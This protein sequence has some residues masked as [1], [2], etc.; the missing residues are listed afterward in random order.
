MRFCK[1]FLYADINKFVTIRD[2]EDDLR[3]GQKGISGIG[4]RGKAKYK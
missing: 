3:D 2:F 1:V 4:S